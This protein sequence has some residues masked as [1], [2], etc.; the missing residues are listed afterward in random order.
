VDQAVRLATVAE[1]I[2]YQVN[3]YKSDYLA[4]WQQENVEMEYG[5]STLILIVWDCL[6]RGLVQGRI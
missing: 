4:K 3:T 6:I 5:V 2:H 1:N